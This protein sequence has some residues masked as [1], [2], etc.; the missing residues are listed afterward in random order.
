LGKVFLECRGFCRGAHEFNLQAV[1]LE[2]EAIDGVAPPAQ[3]AQ[4]VRGF[5]PKLLD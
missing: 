5:S 2:L 3:F 4:L 1:A